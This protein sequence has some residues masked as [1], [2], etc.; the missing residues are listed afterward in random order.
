[1]ATSRSVLNILQDHYPERLG[2]ACIINIPFLINAFFKIILPFV[3]PLTREKIQFNPDVIKEGRFTPDNIMKEHW[4]GS[5]DF[6]YDHDRYWPSLVELTNKQRERWMGTWKELGG[7]VGL[8]EFDYKT[9]ALNSIPTTVSALDEKIA[10]S[11]E[12]F[13][14]RLPEAVAVAA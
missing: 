11:S 5:E 12:A 3:D 14:E 1:M 10:E 2:V 13:N 4:G 9:A 6:V 8:K 7:K